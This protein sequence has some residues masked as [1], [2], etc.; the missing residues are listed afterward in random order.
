M[1]LSFVIPCYNEEDNVELIHNKISE[2]F[3]KVKYD[4]EMIFINDG[5]KDKTILNLRKLVKTSKENIKVIDFSKNFGKEAAIYAGL[6]ESTGD[7][8]SLIDADMQQDPKYVLEMV[9]FLDKNEDYDSVAMYQEKRREGKVLSFFKK[10]FYKLI[11]KISDT[12][13]TSNASDFRTLKRNMVDAILSVKEY[14]RFSKGIFSW[15]GFN[16]YYMPYQ[17]LD[18]AN[19][20]T[21][22]SFKKLFK[23]ALDGIISFTTAPLK[24][25]TYVGLFSSFCSIVYLIVVIIQ[26][27]CFGIDIP[28]YATIIT[29]ILFLGGLQL[30]SLGIIG[31][32]IARTYIEVKERPI[33]IAREVISN[34]SKSW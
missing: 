34:R 16:T 30:F 24:M 8:V 26:K 20:T 12:K 10:C 4:Y 7:L 27:L 29:L 3:K 5:S 18:R 31:E 28:G 11:N 13:F 23:Y 32:Y 15:V 21:K 2:T 1:K 6:K 22:W 17:V 14:Y 9:E 19:G 33:Y 25:A